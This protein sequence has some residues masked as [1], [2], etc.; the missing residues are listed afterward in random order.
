MRNKD[1]IPKLGLAALVFGGFISVV[2]VAYFAQ[3]SQAGAD[4]SADVAHTTVYELN[5][6]NDVAFERRNR[7]YFYDDLATTTVSMRGS[8]RREVYWGLSFSGDMLPGNATVTAARLLIVPAVAGL[9]NISA[10]AYFEDSATPAPFSDTARLSTR[11]LTTASDRYRKYETWSADQEVFVDVTDAAKEFFGEHKTSTQANLIMKGYRIIIPSGAGSEDTIVELEID[12]TTPG[13]TTPPTMPPTQPPTTPPTPPPTTPPTTPPPT[14]PGAVYTATLAAQSGVTSNAT[15]TATLTMTGAL[16]GNLTVSFSGLTSAQTAAH[17]HGPNPTSNDAVL[18]TLPNGNFTNHAVTFTQAQFT[19]LQAGRHYVNIHTNNYTGGEIRGTLMP[20]SGTSSGA[21]F[22]VGKGHGYEVGINLPVFNQ[23]KADVAAGMYNRP[24]TAAEHDKT[25]W[26]SLVNVERKCHYDHQHG[27]DP[28]YVNDLFGEPGAWFGKPGQSVSHVWET[29]ALPAN[30]KYGDA[31][32]QNGTVGQKENDLKHHSYFWLV[33]RDQTCED[34]VTDQIPSGKD[35]SEYCVRDFRIQIH[36]MSLYHEAATRFHSATWEVRFC[37][38]NPEVPGY[39]E[40][41]NCGIMR[42]GLW[43]DWGPLVAPSRNSVNDLLCQDRGEELGPNSGANSSPSGRL[44][45][46][47]NERQF[48][49]DAGDSGA[50]QAFANIFDLNIFPPNSPIRNQNSPAG[51]DSRF[52]CHVDARPFV[53]S[54]PNGFGRHTA[55]VEWWARM[56]H[57]INVLNY[58]PIS[59]VFT[60][61]P[62]GQTL[63]QHFNCAPQV[64]T[65]EAGQQDRR[66]ANANCRYTQSAYSIRLEYQVAIHRDITFATGG[67]TLL[68]SNG[69]SKSDLSPKNGASRT[70]YTNRFGINYH[71][72]RATECPNGPGLD[73]IPII[74]ENVTMS[75]PGDSATYQHR[76]CTGCAVK[77]NHDITPPG[78]PSWNDW[79]YAYGTF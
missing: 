54:N 36:G 66:P 41:E 3:Q 4:A 26:H 17:I 6:I 71:A 47:E 8:S 58:N 52:R 11:S 9:S 33:R 5:D 30:M 63:A 62:G 29:F 21:G 14:T 16:T 12:Y 77:I 28:N 15:G 74:Y 25:K 50:T 67:S 32:N 60:T 37:R 2:A 18:I 68:D 27:D 61:E 46:L 64:Y 69:D 7:M 40:A 35:S 70:F 59:S 78:I 75:G 57:R 38:R 73:C 31:L 51:V 22:G 79:F 55:P 19:D 44:I 20:Q 24:C 53:T 45:Y 23:V 43:S 48:R 1:L 13:T 56:P 49:V 65:N 34:T 10:S 39:N 76:P 42:R 72:K